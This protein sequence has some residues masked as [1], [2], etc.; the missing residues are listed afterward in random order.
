MVLTT[1]CWHIAAEAIPRVITPWPRGRPCPPPHPIAC[2]HASTTQSAGS[3]GGSAGSV[4][5]GRG[6][7]A[8]CLPINIMQ[9]CCCDLPCVSPQLR[10]ITRAAPPP[11]PPFSQGLVC[12]FSTSL[13]YIPSSERTVSARM[14]RYSIDRIHSIRYGR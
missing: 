11:P 10:S 1:F 6:W 9:V 5:P 13:S 2:L 12:A 4:S 3:R 7:S 14:F 8:V